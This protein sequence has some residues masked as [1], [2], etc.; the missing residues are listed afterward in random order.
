MTENQRENIKK[1]QDGILQTVIERAKRDFSE[2]IALIGGTG[3]YFRGAYDEFSDLDLLIVCDTERGHAIGTC[4]LLDGIGYDI[5]CT[6]WEDLEQMA[7]FAPHTM[8][9]HI[10]DPQLFYVRSQ[11]DRE[12][13]LRLQEKAEKIAASAPDADSLR[14]AR[15]HVENGRRIFGDLCRA[16]SLGRC[17]YQAGLLRAEMAAAV[18]QMNNSYLKGSSRREAEEIAALP[19]R[20]D[21]FLVLYQELPARKTREAMEKTAGQ[22]LSCVQN[23]WEQTEQSIAGAGA[24]NPSIQ[25]VLEEF[26]SNYVNKIARALKEEDGNAAFDALIGAQSFCDEMKELFGLPDFDL[27]EDF[28]FD[29]L[30]SLPQKMERVEKTYQKCYEATG[31]SI[32]QYQTLADFRRDYLEKE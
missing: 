25:G 15:V 11:K 17:R 9:S 31:I 7:S 4:F 8:V 2:D 10:I 3:S 30:G 27:L 26:H 21:S 24:Q 20:P 14:R 13:F 28:S 5:Y 22:L 23:L 19:C 18:F 6:S 32:K 16:Q 29:N 12:R 1:R